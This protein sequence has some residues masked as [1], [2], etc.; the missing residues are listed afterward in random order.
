MIERIQPFLDVIL[1]ERAW[2]WTIIGI[3][4][5][6]TGLIVRSWFLK[7]VIRYA[8][9]MDRSYW[10]KIQGAYLKRA[11]GGWIFFFIPWVILVILWYQGLNTCGKRE[12]I[13]L[14]LACIS[15]AV[16]I[17]LHLQAF[18]FAIVDVVKYLLQKQSEKI[19]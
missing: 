16:S 14:G 2:S 10:H 15:Y 18:A 4:Y 19:Y 9:D 1:N 8:K 5:L 7:P 11:V 12:Y 13:L 3:A 6:I 17:L